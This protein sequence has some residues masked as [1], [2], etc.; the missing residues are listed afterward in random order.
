[1]LIYLKWCFDL[2]TLSVIGVP[3]SKL[4]LL[5][6]VIVGYSIVKASLVT[7]PVNDALVISAIVQFPTFTTHL[8]LYRVTSYL[9]IVAYWL[10]KMVL[11]Y[12]LVP[13]VVQDQL[14]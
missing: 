7:M 12:F 4:S 11:C 5:A 1:M 14:H 6:A 10:E 9:P 13:I 3:S 8:D 2:L